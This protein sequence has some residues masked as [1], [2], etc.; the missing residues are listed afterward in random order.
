MA[1]V[2]RVSVDEYLNTEYEPDC[3]YIDGILQE[4]NTGKQTHSRTQVQ[5]GRL[6]LN[7]EAHGYQA[8][9]AQRVQ[10]SASRFRI[11][12]I[13]LV[14][15][16]DKNEVTQTP[17]VLWVEILSPEDRWSRIQSKVADVL[18][19]GVRTAWVIDPYTK[20]AWIATQDAA[21]TEA[22]DRL[23]RC[24]HPAIEIPLDSV[25]PED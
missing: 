12:D 25:L 13:C 24:A 6:L 14:A 2:P 17:P 8:L 22:A 15:E 21:L 3:E 11:P 10:I 23:L 4:R 19:F 7:T 18:R 20:R 1:T 5:L 9:I 16:Q